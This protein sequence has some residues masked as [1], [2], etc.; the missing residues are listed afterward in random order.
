[1]KCVLEVTKRTRGED[2]KD[3]ISMIKELAA[4]HVAQDRLQ[5]AQA[6][7]SSIAE[8][9]M[10]KLRGSRPETLLSQSNAN[11]ALSKQ[12]R[13]E[14]AE[15]LQ[16]WVATE[17]VQTVG[18]SDPRTVDVINELEKF[19]RAREM[20]AIEATARQETLLDPLTSL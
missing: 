9:L 5:D 8:V 11:D 4:I 13:L 12:G 3:T 19:R 20:A 18:R 1:M 6:L 2:H 15:R 16:E 10:R 7:R 17:L 14:E